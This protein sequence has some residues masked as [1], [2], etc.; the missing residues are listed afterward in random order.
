MGF[1]RW[2]SCCFISILFVFNHLTGAF[3]PSVLRHFYSSP[4]ACDT[5]LWRWVTEI[6]LTYDTIFDVVYSTHTQYTQLTL[7]WSSVC[8][9]CRVNSY[10]INTC[11]CLFIYLSPWVTDS[12][13]TCWLD[14]AWAREGGHF[15]V[16]ANIITGVW[17]L[18]GSSK[19]SDIFVVLTS[20]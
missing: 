19:K 11:L 3:H 16:G 10:C 2:S 14:G 9:V 5:W 4:P 12:L 17:I 8:A 7:L 18:Y 6:H 1:T 20:K 15:N 13:Q